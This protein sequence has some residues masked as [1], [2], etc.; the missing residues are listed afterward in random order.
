MKVKH[1]FGENII[2]MYTYQPCPV[3]STYMGFHTIPSRQLDLLSSQQRIISGTGKDWSMFSLQC[4][5][6]DL[7]TPPLRVA[8]KSLPLSFKSGYEAPIFCWRGG[9]AIGTSPVWTASGVSMRE[10]FVAGSCWWIS[11]KPIGQ[12]KPICW[13]I[14]S[15]ICNTVCTFWQDKCEY[16][17]TFLFGACKFP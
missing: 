8:P 6:C 9:E 16:A 2:I 15:Q 3:S 17:H 10:T 5:L 14:V 7:E 1:H 12:H 13:L 11:T 4:Y